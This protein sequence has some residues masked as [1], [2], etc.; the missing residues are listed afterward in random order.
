M[1]KLIILFYNKICQYF[2]KI[3][4]VLITYIELYICTKIWLCFSASS[5][6]IINYIVKVEKI[7]I[8][9]SLFLFT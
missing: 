6:F 8:F 1:Y 5:L 4:R 9:S 2:S 7:A 3:K